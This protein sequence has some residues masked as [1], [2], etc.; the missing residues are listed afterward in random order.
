[1]PEDPV[2]HLTTDL[3]KI[4]FEKLR[5]EF[6]KGRKRT[7]V[8]RLRSITQYRIRELVRL[9]KSRVDYMKHLQAMIDDYN[10]G[11]M[12][13][14]QFFEALV[15][16]MTELDEEEKRHAEENLTEE[17]LAVFDLLTRPPDKLAKKDKET[18]K[19]VARDLLRTLKEEKLVL[20]WRKTQQTRA[21]VRQAIEVELDT[22]LPEIYTKKLYDQKCELVYQHVFE[23]YWGKNQSVYG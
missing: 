9:N 16:L 3:S 6:A 23:S 2:E 7:Y 18:V 12:N 11:R 1:M 10:E 13:V 22:K 19:K 15:Q 20:D 5:K 14:D 4:D 17:E 8:E 21:A